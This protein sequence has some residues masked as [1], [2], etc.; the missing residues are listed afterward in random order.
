M[1]N[2]SERAVTVME[3][4][5]PV[6]AGLLRAMSLALAAMLAVSLVFSSRLFAGE[7]VF[8]QIVTPVMALGLAG[9]L[10]HGFGYRPRSATLA[11]I[12]GPWVA[13]PLILSSLALLV[14]RFG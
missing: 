1:T 3:A 12:L 10:A 13:W 9:T 2:P 11:T 7:A 4:G 5:S 14:F 6:I 8:V